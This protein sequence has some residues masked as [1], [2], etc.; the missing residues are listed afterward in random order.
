MSKNRFK[1]TF[2]VSGQT[3]ILWRHGFSEKQVFLLFINGL[4]KETGHNKYLLRSMFDG[5]IDN[6]R[7][8]RG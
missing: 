8:E 5:S 3:F 6:Y 2:N 7:I 1:G 4:V